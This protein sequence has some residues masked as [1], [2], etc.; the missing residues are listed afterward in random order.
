MADHTARVGMSDDALCGTETGS[1]GQAPANTTTANAN[2]A[3]G[4]GSAGGH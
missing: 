2:T 3:A 1:A 4:G